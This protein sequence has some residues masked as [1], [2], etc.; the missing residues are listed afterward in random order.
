MVVSYHP[1]ERLAPLWRQ[2]S[3]LTAGCAGLGNLFFWREPGRT[4]VSGSHGPFPFE[5]MDTAS[6]IRNKRSGRK[7]EPFRRTTVADRGD[8]LPARTKQCTCREKRVM[9]LLF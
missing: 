4:T 7:G 6:D 1:L 2:P 9:K 5:W 8:P 3:Q